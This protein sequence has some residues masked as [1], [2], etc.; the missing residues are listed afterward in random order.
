M[1]TVSNLSVQFGKRVLFDEVNVTFTQGNCYGIIGAN[2]AGKSTFLKILSGKIEPTSGRVILEPGKRMSVLE[3]DHYAYDEFTVL[4]TVIMGNKVLSAIKKEMDE[5]YADYSDENAD[6]IGELQLQFDEMNGW[7]AE[8][9]AAALLSN[10]GISE[11][12]HYTLMGEMDGK[13]K[14]R[15]LLAQALFG[16]PDVLIMDEPTNDL[17]FET[18]GWLE[19]FLAN[20][21]N[22]VIVV[23]HDRHFLDAVCTHIS[24][25]DFGKINHYSG[26][27]TFWYES[28]QLAARQRA[29]QNKKAEEKAK[30]LQEFIAR[31]SANVAKSKQAT[32]RKK[33]LE[34]LNI[35]EIRPSSRR[36]PAII[37]D[38]EREAGDQILH[39]ENLSV[40]I[41]GEI[42]FQKV[43]IN[44]AKD[45]KVAVISKD[46][47]A[48]TAFYQILNEKQQP[49]SGKFQ[50]GVT[51][52]QSYL[53]VDNSEYFN[54]DYSLVDWLRQWAK[55]EEEREEVY[56][57]GFLG[58]MLF[59]GEEAL[60]KSS[61]LSGG[62]KVRCM[63]S[64]MMM[65]R[66]NV[67]M[68]NEPTNH[69][70][71]ESITAFNNSLKN[72]KGNVLFTTHDHEF[73]QTV[74]NRIIEL[75]PNGVIDR[76]MTFDEYMD[77]KNIQELRKTMYE[78]K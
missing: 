2:G 45:D 9:D 72:F 33:M 31:F 59:S 32:S 27:Y 63:L 16:N 13:L 68:L 53:P 19:N 64:R 73:A 77:D 65:L 8:S 28:S 38:K 36:Y 20:Y 15:V 37:F 25:I 46:S 24:D 17:D 10:L 7:N 29:Q 58:K 23:S 55:T 11:D 66:A 69:L 43:D 51:T 52:S 78:R 5:L 1:L 39:V 54:N 14:V 71:L 35:E 26:N 61:V 22:T 50:W 42:L 70:D 40:S 41:D 44:L 60:K 67:L 21:D 18:I 57:R 62:E 75:T 3:Q 49:D 48:T 56:I 47:R 6:R 34:K 12:M 30:E 4:E 76:Y 74:A